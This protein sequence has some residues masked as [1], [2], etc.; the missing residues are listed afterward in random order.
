MS[1][2]AKDINRHFWGRLNEACRVELRRHYRQDRT[3]TWVASV[4]PEHRRYF[5]KDRLESRAHNEAVR[6]GMLF[7]LDHPRLDEAL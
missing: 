1:D 2:I 4:P 5:V 7:A 3:G 6:N